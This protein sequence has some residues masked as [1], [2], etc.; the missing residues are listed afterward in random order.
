MNNSSNFTVGGFVNDTFNGGS[1]LG[2]IVE[3]SATGGVVLENEQKE[4][5][6]THLNHLKS[7]MPDKSRVDHPTHY[8]GKDD[9]YEAIKVIEAWKLD[10][11][12]GNT[13]KYISRAGKKDATKLLE[14]LE[15]AKWYLQ[16]KID[17]LTK[18]ITH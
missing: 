6:Q 18:N 4:R 16:R 3:I 17:Q 8:G 15:K 10:F 5:W 2:M 14:D 11:P 1:E 12:L 13:V 9:P 7:I